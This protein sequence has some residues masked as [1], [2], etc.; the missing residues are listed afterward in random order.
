MT[1]AVREDVHQAPWTHEE[2]VA[3]L[4]EQGGRYHD[5][6]PFHR[7]MNEGELTR[8]E[9]GRWVANR[10]YYQVCIPLKDA[11]ILSNCPEREV[12][13]EWIQR[14]LDHDG[15]NAERRRDRVVAPSR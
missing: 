15:D 4:R 2:F 14:I 1:S 12:R 3:H 6:H 10:Y 11:A 5:L 13:R 8:Q 7:R 9:L